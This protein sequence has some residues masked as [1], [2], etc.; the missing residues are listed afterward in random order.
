MRRQEVDLSAL[1]RRMA[2]DLRRGDPA[3]FV[4]A[5]GL[6]VTGDAGL[7]RVALENLLGNA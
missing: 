3:R 2:D 5:D 1:A 6:A 7:L 4:I